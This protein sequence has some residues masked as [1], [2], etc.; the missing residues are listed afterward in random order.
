M[1]AILE[2]GKLKQEMDR[3][4]LIRKNAES[5]NLQPERVENVKKIHDAIY[6]LYEEDKKDLKRTSK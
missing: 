1:K 2:I 6:A 3:Q 5:I 4:E